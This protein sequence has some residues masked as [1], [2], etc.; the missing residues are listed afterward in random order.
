[1]AIHGNWNLYWDF[2]GYSDKSIMPSFM[3]FPSECVPINLETNW[4]SKRVMFWHISQ[5]NDFC[6]GSWRRC[7]SRSS[8]RRYESH[9]SWAFPICGP[10]SACP[11]ATFKELQVLENCVEKMSGSHQAQETEGNSWNGRISRPSFNGLWNLSQEFF[12]YFKTDMPAILCRC[13]WPDVWFIVRRRMW[14]KY[15]TLDRSIFSE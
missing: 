13:T 10:A 15:H 8:F 2:T 9:Y 3:V 12:V 1:M 6:F 14:T 4:K 5:C 11:W 7:P